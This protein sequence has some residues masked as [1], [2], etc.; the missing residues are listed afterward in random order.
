MTISTEPAGPSARDGIVPPGDRPHFLASPQ[1]HDDPEVERLYRKQRL[2]AGFRLFARFGYNVG[3][4]GHITAR[5]PELA[6]HY[7]AHPWGMPFSQ[8][9]VSDLVLVGPDSLVLW[10]GPGP[11]PLSGAAFPFH[12]GIYRAKPEVISVAHAHSLYATIWS[13][14]GRTLAPITQNSAAFFESHAVFDEYHGIPFE[15][16]GDN[17]TYDMKEGLQIAAALGD[18][19]A[20]FLK[21]HGPVTV[22]PSVELCV[23]RYIALEYA[24]RLQIEAESNQLSRPTEMPDEVARKTAKMVGSDGAQWLCFNALWQEAVRDW[25]DMFD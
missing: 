22:G 19:K 10:D 13:T 15:N 14:Y 21:N 18:G 5:D 9:R 12:A 1:P 4:A 6:D 17:F 24:A 3:L 8:I 16:D 23:W 2:V 11:R 25:P 20:V 7:W